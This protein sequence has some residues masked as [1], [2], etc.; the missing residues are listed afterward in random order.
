MAQQNDPDHQDLRL[1]G[2][3]VVNHSV[4][5]MILMTVQGDI[6]LSNPAASKL[7]GYSPD[8]LIQGGRSLIVDDEDPEIASLVAVRETQGSACGEAWLTRKDGKR[9][10]AELTSAR[11]EDQGRRRI[12]VIVR[13]V[14]DR[15]ALEY[16]QRLVT[17]A[18]NDS[19]QVICIIDADWTILWANRATHR[20][21]GYNKEQLIGSIAPMRRYLEAEDPETLRA[22]NRSLISTGRWSGEVFTRRRN[23]EVYPL[24]GSFSRAE[25]PELGQFHYITTL[26]DV[27]L[28]RANERKLHDITHF[29]PITWLPNQTYF[30]ELASS[31][32]REMLGHG[33]TGYMIMLDIDHFREVS[34]SHGFGVAD[35]ALRE[36]TSRFNELIGRDNLFARHAGDTF[37]LLLRTPQ[38][39]SHVGALCADLF[40]ALEEPIIVDEVELVLFISV[41]VSAFPN[42]G[43]SLE[44]LLQNAQI[45]MNQVKSEGGNNIGFYDAEADHSGSK[46]LKTAAALRRAIEANELVAYFQPIVDSKTLDVTG[47]EAL[48]RWER[49]D[50]SIIGPGEFLDVA[51]RTGLIGAISDSILRQAC[52]HL[53]ALDRAGVPGLRC[54]V[55]LSAVQFRDPELHNHIISIVQSEGLSPDRL[56]LE[57]TESLLMDNPHQKQSMLKALQD[58]G[59]SIAID[60]F[61][62]GYSSFGYLKHFSVNGIKLDRMFLENVPGDLKDEKLIA[63]LLT[64]G[65][66]LEL[67]VVAEGVETRRQLQ[68]LRQHQCTRLQ[69]F[70]FAPAMS[71][72][73]FIRFLENERGKGNQTP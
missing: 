37:T 19:P 5:G 8:E 7:F 26:T 56:T 29:D 45:A 49:D 4:D 71:S 70:Y 12:A 54:S 41:G 2:A 58:Y 59:I 61:G 3:L 55:N 18:M 42:D 22:I 36:L 23:G 28:I 67:P 43:K 25:S 50:G 13:D 64:V 63:M 62:T 35:E 9:F 31:S 16:R 14:T 33:Q 27:S 48:V 11:F 39:R 17:T 47:M 40:Q 6:L 44:T 65:R 32:L 68:F 21:S 69:G 51:E 1:F 57:I 52:R 73:E 30:A 66:E 10:R 24:F 38:E 20:I 72:N 46:N 60:D 15:Y 53:M 34:E